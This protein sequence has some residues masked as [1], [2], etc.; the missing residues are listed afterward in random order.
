MFRVYAVSRTSL[1]MHHSRLFV[2]LI[3]SAMVFLYSAFLLCAA[4]YGYACLVVEG[5]R[6]VPLTHAGIIA[7]KTGIDKVRVR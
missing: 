6:T 5:S 3:V 1:S 2:F 4:A 7:Y